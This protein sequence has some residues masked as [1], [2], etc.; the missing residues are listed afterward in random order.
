[1]VSTAV[2]DLLG[3]CCVSGK[4]GTNCNKKT[5]WCW[6]VPCSDVEVYCGYE[7]GLFGQGFWDI[8]LG[9]T[10]GL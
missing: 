8:G 7:T 6:A 3:G 10:G 2:G 5:F 9:M 1:M 4:L